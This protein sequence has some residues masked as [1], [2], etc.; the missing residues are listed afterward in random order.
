MNLHLRLELKV[1]PTYL[2]NLDR[3]LFSGF[4]MVLL[5]VVCI[6]IKPLFVGMA[7]PISM[8]LVEQKL[9]IILPIVAASLRVS[10]FLS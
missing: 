3:S 9:M 7:F 5:S 6:S 10:I 4:T 2:Y 1:L 8:E